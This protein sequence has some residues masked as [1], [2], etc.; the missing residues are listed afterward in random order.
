MRL[1]HLTPAYDNDADVKLDQGWANYGPGGHTRP[2]KLFNPARRERH[3]CELLSKRSHC[4][5]TAVS[6]GERSA[7]SLQQRGH[8][9]D[10]FVIVLYDVSQHFF[11]FSIDV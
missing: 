7:E 4:Q 1:R 9:R 10:I 2:V 5:Y 11:S 3:D 6:T 8:H